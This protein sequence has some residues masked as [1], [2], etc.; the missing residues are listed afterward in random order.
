M[1]DYFNTME[2][3]PTN[4]VKANSIDGR[5]YHDDRLRNNDTTPV[6]VTYK[7]KHMDGNGKVGNQVS[8]V[9]PDKTPTCGQQFK[10]YLR[11]TTL[12]GFRYLVDPTPFLLRRIL[13]GLIIIVIFGLFLYSVASSISYFMSY[14][15]STYISVHHNT[16]LRFP[17]ITICSKNLCRISSLYRNGFGALLD[18]QASRSNLRYAYSKDLREFFQTCAQQKDKLILSC[19]FKGQP[20]GPEDFK[21]TYTDLGVC[22]TFTGIT[23]GQPDSNIIKEPGPASGLS[24]FLNTEGEEWTQSWY[25]DEGFQVVVHQASD[26]PQPQAN[27]ISISPATATNIGLQASQSNNLAPPFG[28]CGVTKLKLFS[29]YSHSNCIQECLLSYILKAC[30]CTLVYSLRSQGADSLLKMPICNVKTYEKCAKAARDTFYKV[31]IGTS[32][33][34]PSSCCTFNYQPILSQSRL[35]NQ[36]VERLIRRN[37]AVPKRLAD[38]YAAAKLSQYTHEYRQLEGDKFQAVIGAYRNATTWTYPKLGQSVDDIVTVLRSFSSG[39]NGRNQFFDF[40][41]RYL[42]E[43]NDNYHSKIF[44]ALSS[45][46]HLVPKYLDVV[47][48]LSYSK[49]TGNYTTSSMSPERIKSVTQTKMDDF[50]VHYEHT[51]LSLDKIESLYIQGQLRDFSRDQKKHR[52]DFKFGLTALYNNISALSSASDGDYDKFYVVAEHFSQTVWPKGAQAYEY[53]GTKLRNMTDN[54]MKFQRGLTEVIRELAKGPKDWMFLDGSQFSTSPES[55]YIYG[56]EQK[57]TNLRD[58]YFR[59]P[60]NLSTRLMIIKAVQDDMFNY[61]DFMTG[62]AGDIKRMENLTNSALTLLQDIYVQIIEAEMLQSDTLAGYQI[63]NMT[64][65]YVD[66]TT[67]WKIFAMNRELFRSVFMDIMT[68]VREKLLP[69]RE[70]RTYYRSGKYDELIADARTMELNV[71]DSLNYLKDYMT[72]FI[73]SVNIEKVLQEKVYREHFSQLNIYFQDTS[74][75][76]ESQIASYSLQKL[77]A[78]IGLYLAIFLGSS[79]FIIIELIDFILHSLATKMCVGEKNT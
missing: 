53:Y 17:A 33:N 78:D 14:P 68:R 2:M 45:A 43:Y 4:M 35:S 76:V 1:M 46:K 7:P 75:K 31:K 18:P 20:C 60:G 79:I 56:A 71:T 5:G 30:N 29:A 49:N 37:D 24:L 65:T 36:Y 64:S 38:D 41:K 51:M 25:G 8:V 10:E 74:Y 15:T 42:D 19:A 72:Y 66:M 40:I 62:L 67:R 73:N 77:L 47:T 58:E 54:M 12:H 57:W 16:S 52:F 63:W 69:R 55:S 59:N 22:Y 39:Q 21:V 11:N 44:S 23:D 28:S 27:G 13:W 48:A 3:K 70:R 9:Q 50:R 32:C 6:T 34:C 61:T 26:Y